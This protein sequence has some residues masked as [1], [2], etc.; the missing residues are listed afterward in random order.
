MVHEKMRPS[1][2]L[3]DVRSLAVGRRQAS[4]FNI[5]YSTLIWQVKGSETHFETA[6]LHPW[7]RGPRRPAPSF[8][9]IVCH[10][11][12]TTDFVVEHQIPGPHDEDGKFKGF[13]VGKMTGCA[14]FLNG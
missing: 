3:G 1:R 14:M 13:I 11:K 12:S 8:H 9:K 2:D 7:S 5:Q 4:I 6:N 10:S